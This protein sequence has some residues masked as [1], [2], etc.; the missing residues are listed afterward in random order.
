MLLQP[1]SKTAKMCQSMNPNKVHELQIQ[2][3]TIKLNG[4]TI[5]PTLH[6]DYEG[7]GCDPEKFQA[8]GQHL[9]HC[10]RNKQKDR[11]ADGKVFPAET[12]SAAYLILVK[13]VRGQ[14]GVQESC[15]QAGQQLI[16]RCRYSFQHWQCTG[17]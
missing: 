12:R 15:G 3:S 5:G 10:C 8:W 11:Q 4:F 9:I 17:C 13:T 16:H 2:K 7:T 6:A 1:V 14:D